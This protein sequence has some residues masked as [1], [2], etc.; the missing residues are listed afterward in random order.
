MDLPFQVLPDPLEPI[1]KSVPKNFLY[2]FQLTFIFPQQVLYVDI[3]LFTSCLISPTK[4]CLGGVGVG[5]R[6]NAVFL[7]FKKLSFDLSDN[8]NYH[9]RYYDSDFITVKMEL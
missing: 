2:Q 8:F 7:Y 3:F 9:D 4:L 6:G 1:L 5:I